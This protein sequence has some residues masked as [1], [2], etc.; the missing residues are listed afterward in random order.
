VVDPE[1]FDALSST[2]SL[3]FPPGKHKGVAV[4]VLDPRRNEVMQVH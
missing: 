1:R 4:K 2:V 3:P